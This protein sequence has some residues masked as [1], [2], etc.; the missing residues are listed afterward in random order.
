MKQP[1][2]RRRRT[3]RPALN[4]VTLGE[5]TADGEFVA[6]SRQIEFVMAF[7]PAVCEGKSRHDAELAK[8]IGVHRSVISP[9]RRQ[10]GFQQ[11]VTNECTAM[12]RRG[13]ELI[14]ARTLELGIRGSIAHAEFYAK[15]SGEVPGGILRGN[16]RGGD[17][18]HE[19]VGYTVHIL[20]PAPEQRQ[21][22]SVTQS[23]P[24]AKND[25]SPVPVLNLGRSGRK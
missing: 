15:Y 10:Q 22:N 6:T 4:E 17:D 7:L 12:R 11:W 20:V 25:K 23:A 19:A 2:S 18:R 9:W 1:S 5:Q 16:R 3:S 8:Q 14:L 21:P 13:L 24:E